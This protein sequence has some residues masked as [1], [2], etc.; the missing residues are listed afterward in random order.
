M[1]LTKII[2][3]YLYFAWQEKIS[4][5]FSI[6]F[7]ILGA[8]LSAFIPVFYG[9]IIDNT[10]N[11]NFD[12]AIKL[13]LGLIIIKIISSLFNLLREIFAD[14]SLIKAF[15]KNSKLEYIKALQ[16]IDYEF[17]TNKSSGSLISL[18]KRGEN[19]IF[20]AFWEIN[21]IA[22]RT[23]SEF[24]IT[25]IIL[26][27]INKTIAL[28]LF[29]S[30]LISFIAGYFLIKLNI[31]K[32]IIANK[33]D[34]K[35]TGLVVDNLIGFETVKIF[36]QE[37]WERIRF[38][39]KYKTW[40]K[41]HFN[42]VITFRY[43]DITLLTISTISLFIILFT[44]IDAVSKNILTIGSFVTA[45]YYVFDINN[46]L[47]DVVYKFREL[48]KSYTD[49]KEYFQIINLKPKIKDKK[50]S[51]NINTTTGS[52]QFQNVSF[53]YNGEE[54]VLSNINLKIKPNSKIA[55]VGK[56]GSG[57]TTLTKLLLRFYDVTKGE[58]Y[59]DNINIKNLKLQSLRKLIGLVPQEPILFNDTIK[60]NIA[61]AKPNTNESNIFNA[62]KLA[63]LHDFILTLPKG[64]NTIVG[65]RGIKLSGGQK[66][67]LAIARIIIAD[68]EIIIFDE[69]TSQLDSVNEKK[70]QSAFENLTKNKTTIIIAHRL[71]T[72]MNTDQIFVFSNGTIVQNGKHKKLINEKGIYQKLWKLQT[73]HL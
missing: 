53:E 15:W 73:K 3:K 72:I 69:A 14:N 2:K 35:I 68:P 39:N 12:I 59:I 36:A 47:F 25:V 50:N 34:D 17:H 64:Y 30:I 6:I 16:N 46:R 51:K 60:Y 58:I 27:T 40:V 49:L 29:T 52:I 10:E 26:F 63:N 32:R 43:I 37:L 66:Q 65:E 4:Y 56:S 31:K 61:Y 23:I 19:A 13:S 42:Y 41:A 45:I 57:K 21:I 28:M 44:S 20:I 18:A 33:E 22:M 48:A 11:K 5:I 70:I 1:S 54:E 9:Q 7:M 55:L 62:A 71:S 24:L 8:L 38:K 67:R